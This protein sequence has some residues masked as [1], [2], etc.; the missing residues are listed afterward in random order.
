MIYLVRHGLDDERFIGGY[1]DVGLVDLGV[2]QIEDT[3]K[4]LRKQNFD[5]RKIYTSDI[6]RAYESAEIINKYLNLI[7]KKSKKF[8]EQNKGLLNGMDRVKAIELYP[9]YI[10]TESVDMRYPEGESLVDLYIRTIDWLMDVCE[11]D[12]S[13]I[14]THRG[15][16]NMI[17]YFTRGDKLD[18][19]KNRYDVEHSSV[20]EFDV[21]KTRIRRIK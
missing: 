5:I 13:L 3:G 17:Y 12:N 18:M 7:V 1:S 20:H 2:K 16:I 11:Y 8:R 19:D 14:V 21:N 6:T 4:W 9:K 15:V 10:S